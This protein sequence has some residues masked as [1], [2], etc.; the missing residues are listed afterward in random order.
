ME[1]IDSVFMGACG[2][3]CPVWLLQLVAQETNNGAV[4]KEA[5]HAIYREMY[6][7]LKVNK[8]QFLHYF[9]HFCITHPKF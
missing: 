7:I 4:G 3:G 8:M 1:I 9:A 5:R 6:K 2:K